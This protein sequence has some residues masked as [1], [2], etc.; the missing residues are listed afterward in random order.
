MFK[1]KKEDVKVQKPAENKCQLHFGFSFGIMSQVAEVE[2]NKKFNK[3]F[4]LVAVLNAKN[5]SISHLITI[6]Q[7]FYF[8]ET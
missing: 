1:N 4:F 7:V 2:E 8:D 3:V 5:E 6:Q